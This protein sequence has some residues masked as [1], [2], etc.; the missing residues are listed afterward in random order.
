MSEEL[1]T[2][3]KLILTG[4]VP[5]GTIKVA[6]E[7]NPAAGYYLAG[8]DGLQP[9]KSE[10]HW[11]DVFII[12]PNRFG[13][14][15]GDLVRRIDKIFFRPLNYDVLFAIKEQHPFLNIGCILATANL[16]QKEGDKK[17]FEVPMLNAQKEVVV[18]TLDPDCIPEPG[19]WCIAEQVV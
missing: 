8:V 12:P 9:D 2:L 13:S 16:R 5:L 19:T 6:V 11:K 4:F 14:T 17:I 18:F 7:I 1:R 3:T 10:I 15:Y